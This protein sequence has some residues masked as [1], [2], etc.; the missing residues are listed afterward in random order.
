MKSVAESVAAILPA[1]GQGSRLRGGTRKQFRLL[2]NKPLLVHSLEGIMAAGVVRWFVVVVPPADL[3][4]ARDLLQGVVPHGIALEVVAGGAR[5]QDSVAAG[6]AVLPDG[7]QVVVVHDAVRPFPRPE[8][9]T[10]TVALCQSFDGAIVALPATDT[11]KEVQLDRAASRGH[12]GTIEGTLPRDRVWQAQ[13]PQAFRVEVLRRAFQHAGEQGLIGT[14]EAALV[15]SIGGRV[16]V[17][18]GSPDNIK[19]TTPEDW[20]YLEWK[21][22]HTRRSGADD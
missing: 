22:S 4:A 21:L 11:L 8:W 5:R 17:V 12:S 1:A 19:V 13:T 3:E 18:A 14:D 10:R 6:L 15:E 20:A 7:Y 9:I 16:A 2:G